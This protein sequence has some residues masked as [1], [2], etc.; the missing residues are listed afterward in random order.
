MVGTGACRP[1]SCTRFSHV[2]R[3]RGPPSAALPVLSCATH[4]DTLLHRRHP[5][6]MGD[7]PPETPRSVVFT[8]HPC[9]SLMRFAADARI[10]RLPARIVCLPLTRCPPLHL[11]RPPDDDMRHVAVSAIPGVRMRPVTSHN[12][13]VDTALEL[14]TATPIRCAPF[15]GL[16]V[17][18][19]HC[20]GDMARAKIVGPRSH[21]FARELSIGASSCC[22]TLTMSHAS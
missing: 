15:N 6:A 8:V 4:P 1:M 21:I 13:A 10:A 22:V 12:C 7:A 16:R 18:N 20:H 11:A 3:R 5:A 19:W 17:R 9:A 2:V 14:C